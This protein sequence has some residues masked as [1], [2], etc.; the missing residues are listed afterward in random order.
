MKKIG[1]IV[2]LL[3]VFFWANIYSGY[4]QLNQQTKAVDVNKDGKPDVTYHSDGKYVS[5][6][7]ADTNY[8]GKPDVIVNLENG[9][10]KSA[11][12]D[13]DYDG[14]VDKKFGNAKEF[15]KWLNEKHPDFKD[16]LS[17]TDWQFNLLNF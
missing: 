4:S 5:K 11:Q 13:T 3:S 10:F 12:A 2:I 9:K 7:E 6:I 16:K 15:D 8:D 1:V 17:R 14:K